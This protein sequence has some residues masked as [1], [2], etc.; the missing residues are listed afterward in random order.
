LYLIKIPAKRLFKKLK[1]RKFLFYSNVPFMRL[2]VKRMWLKRALKTEEGIIMKTHADRL[3]EYYEQKFKKEFEDL[4]WDWLKQMSTRRRMLVIDDERPIMYAYQRIFSKEGFDVLIASNAIVANELLVR[5]KID[6]VLLDI[7]MPE[8]D[9]TILFELI[10]AFHRNIKVVV[11]SVYPIDE[12][13]EKIKDA[14]AYF[15]K[16]DGKEVLLKIISSLK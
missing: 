12:Q 14:D 4:D 16:S 3:P 9:G 10:R 5:E 6:I 8:V 15:D 11:S 13:K 2:L 7:N 1:I